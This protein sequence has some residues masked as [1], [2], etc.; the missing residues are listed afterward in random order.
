[1]KAHASSCSFL[2]TH[3]GD[4]YVV[5]HESMHVTVGVLERTAPEAMPILSR[6]F[7]AKHAQVPLTVKH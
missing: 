2:A 5:R 3:L 7:H 4:L 1:M 6:F